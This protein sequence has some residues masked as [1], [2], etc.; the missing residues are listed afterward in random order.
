MTDFIFYPRQYPTGG[1]NES[2][3]GIDGSG[4][5]A[6][7]GAILIQPGNNINRI[8]T[9]VESGVDADNDSVITPANN[10][11]AKRWHKVSYSGNIDSANTAAVANS[12]NANNV[13]FIQAGN[14]SVQRSSRDK[15]RDYVHAADYGVLPNGNSMTEAFDAMLADVGVSGKRRIKFDAGTY[16]FNTKPANITTGIILV[17]EGM[18]LTTFA[19]NYSAGSNNEG[20]MTWHG[21]MTHGAGAEHAMFRSQN[22]TTDGTML[23]FSTNENE[24]NGYH[25]IDHIVVTYQ[26]TGNHHR[27]LLVDGL[28][29]TI[30]GSQGLRDFSAIRCFMFHGNN[31]NE[32]IRF[33][34]S[35]NL[36]TKSLWTNGRLVVTG[37]NNALSRTTDANIDVICLN[38]TFVAN[39]SYVRV[40]G[41]TDTLIFSNNTDTCVFEGIIKTASG[42]ISVYGNNCLVLTNSINPEVSD[43]NQGYLALPGG[44][45]L[46]WMR[47]SNISTS[48]STF[49]WPKAFPNAV[50]AVTATARTNSASTIFSGNH[51]TG[52]ASLAASNNG[53]D[54]QVIAIGY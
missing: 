31:A 39:A 15:M 6:G 11:G 50:V 23:V 35:T 27:C 49:A 5:K 46:Q 19:R 26:G 18:S 42:G 13:T 54:A 2:L 38:Q 25:R 33:I 17:G 7:D 14:N 28:P 9:L 32:T 10:A 12:A 44:M 40:S 36:Q 16:I 24:V 37:G 51:S 34:N 52:N 1:N 45:L 43:N 8:Y 4:L 22:G 21:N 53:A 3:D 48:F 47:V 20:F 41:V 29:N 30:S